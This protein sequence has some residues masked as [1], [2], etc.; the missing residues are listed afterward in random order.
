MVIDGNEILVLL[1]NKDFVDSAYNFCRELVDEDAWRERGELRLKDSWIQEV[2]YY[3]AKNL[4]GTV[5][6]TYFDNNAGGYFAVI[7]TGVT[8]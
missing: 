5:K 6:R 4:G 7:Q 3:A 8:E 1:V 2:A